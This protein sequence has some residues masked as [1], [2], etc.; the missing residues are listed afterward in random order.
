MR[1]LVLA[2][3]LIGLGAAPAGAAQVSYIDGGQVWIA[4]LDG[5]AKRSLSGPSPDGYTW[6]W[7]AQSDDGYVIGVRATPG[8]FNAGNNAATEWG[9]DGTPQTSGDTA[10]APLTVGLGH[11]QTNFPVQLNLAPGGRFVNYGYSECVYIT[12]YTC[13]FGS[14][15]K[16]VSWSIAPLDLSG[17]DS[18]GLAGN[19]IIGIGYGSNAV[20]VQNATSNGTMEPGFTAWPGVAFDGSVY[21]NALDAS[22]DGTVTGISVSVDHGTD[23]IQMAPFASLGAPPTQ[24]DALNA[25]MLPTQGDADA[26]NVSADGRWIAWHDARGVVVAGAPAWFP[27]ADVSTCALSSPAVVISP[28]GTYPQLGGSTAATPPAT[29][30]PPPPGGGGGGGGTTTAPRQPTATVPAKV[31]ASAFAKGLALTVTV[32][33]G[34]TVTATAKV[35]RT[36]LAKASK[37]AKA[38]GKVTL[39]LKASKKLKLRRYRGK[40]LVITIKAPGGTVTLK[41]K[42]R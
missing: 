32:P 29:T 15:T 21:V 16:G 11:T 20:L 38:A 39:K 40:T 4:T 37:Q 27:S 23:Q 6:Q 14:Y 42:L 3:A 7:Q 10:A 5:T 36:V 17:V 25:C 22:A 13:S 31:K 24:Q 30:T 28:T 18:P 19:R 2:L 34:G 1:T 33:Q 8:H 12:Q 35:G 9:P 26:I 41:R